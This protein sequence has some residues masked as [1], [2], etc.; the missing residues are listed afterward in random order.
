MKRYALKIDY[1]LLIVVV[2]LVFIGTLAVFS[3]S[4]YELEIGLR[5][6]AYH[7]FKMNLLYAAVG[8]FLMISVSFFPYEGI[9]KLIKYIAIFTIFTMI[10]VVANGK[11]FYGAKRWIVVG[12][13]TFMPLELA[14]VTLILIIAWFTDRVG[15]NI[16]EFKT[17]GG[18]LAVCFFFVI[19]AIPE[20]DLATVVLMIGL[21]VT[22]LFVAGADM[23]YLVILFSI[24]AV[25]ALVLLYAEP[26]RLSRISIWLET[27][28]DRQYVFSDSKRQIMNSI[29]AI[30]SGELIG[31][32]IGMS[33][34]S[35]LRLPEAYSDFIFSI[36][37]EEFG[38]LGLLGILT[39]Y[40]FLVYRLF[41]I[42]I[43]CD[44][45]FGF[46]IAAGTGIL[47]LLQVII[48]VGVALAILPTTGITLPFISKGGT[49]LVVLLLLIGVVLNISSSNKERKYNIESRKERL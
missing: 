26:Y 25:F 33:D 29:Y 47:I 36:V 45:V 28:S 30:S 2:L 48:N 9:K 16:R 46:T 7:Y 10:Y 11:D 39:L 1:M 31:K 17:F 15:R 49:S 42:A 3:A 37:V 32:G 14:K 44:D 18:I 43:D 34:F 13:I 8:L 5:Q 19:L 20:K 22:L 38:F 6:E 4:Y 41:K 23:K 40:A 24:G 12:N 21:I 35:K 27:F